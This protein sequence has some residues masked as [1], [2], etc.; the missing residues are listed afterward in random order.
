VSRRHVWTV[1]IYQQGAVQRALIARWNGKVWKRVPAPKPGGRDGG[2][3][4]SGVTVSSATSAWTVGK[5]T[6]GVSPHTLTE[7]WNGRKWKHVP[8]PS[9]GGVN[10]NN[11][12]LV[13]VTAPSAHSAWAVGAISNGT[14]AQTLA[15]HCC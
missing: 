7:H 15:V 3:A 6:D 2:S 9:P 4:L 14:A 13:E 11:P 12:S 8:S 1:G 10:E 5:Y